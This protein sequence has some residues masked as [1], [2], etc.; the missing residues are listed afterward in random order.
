MATHIYTDVNGNTLN[1]TEL[2][3]S[4]GV[5]VPNDLRM[6]ISDYT[7]INMFAKFKPVKRALVNGKR[8]SQYWRANNGNC[9]IIVPPLNSLND[10]GV[11]NWKYDPP[12]GGLNENE[13]NVL[14][15]F[16]FYGRYNQYASPVVCSGE[17]EMIVHNKFNNADLSLSLRFQPSYEGASGIGI[18]DIANI[19]NMYA[20]VSL[21]DTT[22]ADNTTQT[23]VA[24][25]SKPYGDRIIFQKAKI[26]SLKD[27]YYNLYYYLRGQPRNYG[28][29]G[30]G[31]EIKP[32]YHGLGYLNP[33]PLRI[34]SQFPATAEIT[35]V[36][37]M[38][39]SPF[40]VSLPKEPAN[41]FTNTNGTLYFSMNV[42][43][44]DSPLN[45]E[46]GSLK[47][48]VNGYHG[49][50]E[51]GIINS[52]VQPANTSKSYTIEINFSTRNGISVPPPSANTLMQAS[53]DVYFKGQ[54]LQI[55][56]TGAWFYM[57]NY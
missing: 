44:T 6:L 15:D 37:G 54:N 14:S 4:I 3:N 51:I 36:N 46:S 7:P 16:Y 29:G 47:A 23:S 17:T 22:P 41:A 27:G 52:I 55:L 48:I 13:P 10:I 34:I 5:P 2:C 42:V 33:V 40:F 35:G 19:Q 49:T 11:T 8:D 57:K 32:M 21:T 38:K 12:R 24:T 26:N 30:Q 39:G 43:T 18:G 9:G 45:I 31:S 1:E 50:D 56:M 25:I 20:A 28:D 53:F